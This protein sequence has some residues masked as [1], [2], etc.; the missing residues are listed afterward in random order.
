M[1]IY[2]HKNDLPSDINLGLEVAMI[3][4]K[5]AHLQEQFEALQDGQGHEQVLM[6]IEQETRRW[7]QWRKENAVHYSILNYLQ[8]RDDVQII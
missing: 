8:I 7:E 3:K 2:L 6:E 5:L 4:S 1:A